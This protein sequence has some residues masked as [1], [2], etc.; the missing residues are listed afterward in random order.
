MSF[1]KA[2]PRILTLFALVNWSVGTT[3]VFGLRKNIYVPRCAHACRAAIQPSPL[4]CTSSTELSTSAQCYASNDP[5]LQ[6]LAYCVYSQCEGITN[7]D[8]ENY[9][10]RYVVGWD[11]TTPSPKYNYLTA[12]DLA[13]QPNTTLRYGKSLVKVS[14]V[15]E[16]D[17]I[18]A[19]TSLADWDE[20]EVY[21]TR[22][23]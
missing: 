2:L 14:L 15:P 20:S 8:L 16:N 6:T 21:H 12:L 13:S 9:W 17:Y 22:F 18:I 11:L 10:D 19:Y 7:S 23:A 4:E 1:H 3:D 5:F